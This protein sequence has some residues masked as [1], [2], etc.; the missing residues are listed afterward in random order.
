M[1]V[2]DSDYVE[3]LTEIDIQTPIPDIVQERRQ[4]RGFLYLGCRFDDQMLRTYA[5]QI[6]KRSVGPHHAVADAATL[7]GNELR[8]LAAEEIT[9][10]DLPLAD[11]ITLL[12]D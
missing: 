10:I 1:L 2:S 3:V 9:L 11:A 5:R 4:G 6:K 7:T 12:S 8:F